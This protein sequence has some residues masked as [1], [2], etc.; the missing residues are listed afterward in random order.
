MPLVKRTSADDLYHLLGELEVDIDGLRKKK[1]SYNDLAKM[2]LDLLDA[3]LSKLPYA[4][5]Y[6]P[7]FD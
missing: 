4:G 2:Y 3:K 6:T 5:N 1:P 7:P